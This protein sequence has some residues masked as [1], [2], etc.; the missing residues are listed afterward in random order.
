MRAAETLRIDPVLNAADARRRIARRA[1][2]MQLA[3]TVLIAAAFLVQGVRE[4]LGAAAGGLAIT[5]G[6]A[7][8]AWRALAGGVDSA[9]GALQRLVGGMAYKWA[10]VVLVLYLALAQ[11]ALDPLAVM[12]GFLAALLANL[13]AI[14]FRS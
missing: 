9:A 10:T 14:A 4:A 5:L 13:V 2:A 8:M 6:C 1:V 12:S 11:W 7:L 3:T